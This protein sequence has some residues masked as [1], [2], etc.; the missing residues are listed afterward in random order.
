MAF[1]PAGVLSY[2]DRTEVMHRLRSRILQLPPRS[3]TIDDISA[4]T[5]AFI[6]MAPRPAAPTG[7]EATTAVGL[8]ADLLRRF[9]REI[10]HAD[11]QVA[12]APLLSDCS[13]SSPC[14]HELGA[15]TREGVSSSD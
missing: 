15:P 5:R 6:R 4:L 8:D 2:E 1:A 10:R 3:F 9:S 7:A 11:F 13:L 14:S 12:L